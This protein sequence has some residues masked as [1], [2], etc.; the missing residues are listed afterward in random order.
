MRVIETKEPTENGRRQK[1]RKTKLED[2]KINYEKIIIII[3]KIGN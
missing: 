3:M 2:E 1:R